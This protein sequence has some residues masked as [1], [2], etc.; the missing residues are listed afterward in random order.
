VDGTASLFTT[1]EPF[2]KLLPAQP[3]LGYLAPEVLDR[4]T[5]A[6]ARS[7][8]FGLGVMLWEALDNGRLFPHRRAEAI[9][10]LLAR[11]S[12]PNPRVDQ[13]WAHPLTAVAMKA[14][15]RDRNQRYPDATGFWL[16][17]REHLPAPE[18]SRATLARRAQRAL[19]LELTAEVRDGPPYLTSEPLIRNSQAPPPAGSAFSEGEPSQRY[20]MRP[21]PESWV[22]PPSSSAPRSGISP[23]P[24]SRPKPRSVRPGALDAAREPPVSRASSAS[25]RVS[26]RVARPR[27]GAAVTSPSSSPAP[28]GASASASTARRDTLPSAGASSQ[29]DRASS[30]AV[31]FVADGPVSTLRVSLP[32][33]LVDSSL[34]YYLSSHAPPKPFP[35]GMLSFAAIIFFGVGAAVAFGA[36]TAMRATQPAAAVGPTASVTASPPTLAV[37]AEPPPVVDPPAP[38]SGAPASVET[39]ASAGET[40]ETEEPE[41]AEEANRA[42]TASR[43]SSARKKKARARATEPRRSAPRRT[44]PRTPAEEPAGSSLPFT[45][46]PY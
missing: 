13:E 25:P 43:T 8:V 39:T 12:L 2:G 31:A 40:R 5:S 28:H 27:P 37:V 6:D 45:T 32:P 21:G 1:R 3:D 29:P 10:R 11:G 41:E 35:W 33:D 38:A 7:D 42:E 23:R 22:S 17:L 24:S 20:S 16:A 26:D 14:L 9:S 19:Q 30:P 36:V 34:P 4:S 46:Q 15:H 18:D 44:E